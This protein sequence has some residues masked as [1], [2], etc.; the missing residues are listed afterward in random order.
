MIKDAELRD[1]LY[2]PADAI[3]YILEEPPIEVR[4]RVVGCDGGG[5]SLGHPKVFINLDTGVPHACSYCGLRFV[6]LHDHH[7]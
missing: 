4:D 3:D 6:R 2:T 7:H 1:Q 5:G